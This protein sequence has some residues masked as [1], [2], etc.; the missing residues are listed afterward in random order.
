MTPQGS[1][2][3]PIGRTLQARVLLALVLIGVLP[4]ALVGLGVAALDRQALV[5]QSSQ[6]LIG[7]ARGFADELDLHF[8]DL[9]SICR[10]IA[11]LPGILGMDPAAQE[12][13]LKQLFPQFQ[14]FG[15]L[16]TFDLAGRRVASSVEGG[17]DSIADRSA[18]QTAIARGQQAW[19]VD[20]AQSS[21]RSSLT[22]VTPIRNAA[23]EMVGVVGVVVDM[24]DL[25]AVLE[26]A[27]AGSG[28]ETFV[29][30]ED[31]R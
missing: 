27:T 20:P 19:A 8:E 16:S 14:V 6:E 1:R 29:L 15:R 11:V 9:T 7:L 21:G 18:F 30:D 17:A 3:V 4:L 26:R 12:E 23:R 22:I 13:A 24:A 25:S 2:R 28:G 5:D 10:G 31:G